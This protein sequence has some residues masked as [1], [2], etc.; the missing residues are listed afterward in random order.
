MERVVTLRNPSRDLDAIESL[1]HKLACAEGILNAV[2]NTFGY[3]DDHGSN[4]PPEMLHQAIQAAQDLI[5]EC[6]Q[7]T[8]GL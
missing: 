1:D 6:I 5:D 8:K 2:G 7:I 4:M 3:A